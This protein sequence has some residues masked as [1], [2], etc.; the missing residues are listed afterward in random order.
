M[1][2]I[3]LYLI[4]NKLPEMQL[5]VWKGEGQLPTGDFKCLQWLVSDEAKQIEFS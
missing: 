3:D 2:S 1:S 5:H 4:D